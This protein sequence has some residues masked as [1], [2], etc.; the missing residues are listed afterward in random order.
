MDDVPDWHI[1]VVWA[2]FLEEFHSLGPG[3]PN[4]EFGKARIVAHCHTLT[5]RHKLLPNLIEPDQKTSSVK[6]LKCQTKIDQDSYQSGLKNVFVSASTMALESSV[7]GLGFSTL[8]DLWATKKPKDCWGGKTVFVVL[9]SVPPITYPQI[10]WCPIQRRVYHSNESCLLAPILPLLLLFPKCITCL[11]PDP[12]L[13][14]QSSPY[15][16]VPRPSWS[17][18]PFHIPSPGWNARQR[19]EV[20]ERW[21]KSVK[22][23]QC[24]IPINCKGKFLNTFMNSSAKKLRFK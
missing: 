24:E 23:D 15:L 13:R 20:W 2:H 12:F 10:Q 8:G 17:T 14:N 18:W 22:L 16:L 6:N 19:P 4:I 21:V 9:K 1:Y 7:V 5:R 3:R 11:C